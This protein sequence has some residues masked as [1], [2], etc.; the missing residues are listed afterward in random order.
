MHGELDDDLDQTMRSVDFPVMC[1]LE[2]HSA[3][4]ISEDDYDNFS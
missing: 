4:K 3:A 1:F 2:R